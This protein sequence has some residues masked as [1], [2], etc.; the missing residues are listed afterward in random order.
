MSDHGGTCLNLFL[1]SVGGA[2]FAIEAEQAVGMEP[3]TGEEAEDLFWFHK[4]LGFGDGMIVYRLP[5]IVTIRTR[6]SRPYRV[7]IDSMED[8]AEFSQ[9]DIRLFPELLEPF[10][11][12]N[13]MWGILPRNGHLVLLVD[14]QRLLMGK[15]PDKTDTESE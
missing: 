12:R 5:T 3:Y 10:A 1:F 14:F 4:E 8:I 9:N 11:L 13:G 2:H 15:R 7:I 6:D